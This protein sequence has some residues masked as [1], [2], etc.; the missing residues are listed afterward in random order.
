[1]AHR[2][3]PQEA[4][5]GKDWEEK[6][7]QAGCA[8]LQAEATQLLK[9]LDDW[10]LEQ[11]PSGWKVVGFRKRTVVCRFGA[12][13]I[14]RRLYQDGEG[15]Y[16]FLLDEYLAWE[17][18]QAATPWLGEAAVSLAA[19][20]S[21]REVAATLEKVTA[22][23]L[24]STTVHQLVQKTAE[25]AITQERQEVEACYG[26]GEAPSGGRIRAVPRL[27]LEADGLYVRL[28]REKQKHREVKMA[29]G[30]EGWERLLQARERYRVVGKRVYCQGSEGID[31]WEGAILAFGRRWDWSRIPLVVLNGDGARWID[32]GVQP[33]ERAIRQLDRFHLAR[34]CYHT[35]G[36]AGPEL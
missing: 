10:L 33:F 21:F 2:V 24:S 29:I 17:A 4:P 11:S 6:L 5:A 22:G 7:Y 18:Y 1:M 19:V 14:S 12:V 34:S 35:G 31:F 15:N 9:R 26:R 30:Y 8:L 3:I 25:K 27:F 36:E 20:T 28:Q 32:E 16:H 13:T 23:V